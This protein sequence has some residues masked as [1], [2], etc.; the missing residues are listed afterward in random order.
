[1]SWVIKSSFSREHGG[2]RLVHRTDAA[3]SSRHKTGLWI[4]LAIAL[5][6]VTAATQIGTNRTPDFLQDYAAGWAWLHG[7]PMDTPTLVLAERFW[8]VHGFTSVQWLRQPH[9]PFATLLAI[10]FAF[11]SFES[12]R[13][14]WAGICV[15]AL[16]G[17]WYVGRVK[18]LNALSTAPIWCV[19]IVLG[20]HEP[21]LAL[22]IAA[23]IRWATI[24]PMWAGLS[25]GLAIALKCYPALLVVALGVLGMYRTALWATGIAVG[26]TLLAECCLG[27]GT[28]F[29]WL[30]IM[31]ENTARYV[32][33][34]SNGSLVRMVRVYLPLP[35]VFVAAACSVLLLTPL[36]LRRHT[37]DRQI[38]LQ[39]MISAM[40]LAS[41][42]SWRHYTGLAGF[43]PLG[44]T[45]HLLLVV[46]GLATL[47]VGMEFLPSAPETIIQI[48]LVAALCWQWWTCYFVQTSEVPAAEKSGGDGLPYYEPSSSTVL[49][50]PSAKSNSLR[51]GTI[52]A[53]VAKPYAVTIT[54]KTVSS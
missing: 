38:A 20:T 14:I 27:W 17:A 4:L 39:G 9:P 47:L 3:G 16:L 10:P 50:R 43:G 35:A 45:Q 42:L 51:A 6:S 18:P 21:L 13:W 49:D 44:R 19:A 25:L 2:D 34:S 28:L 36:Y 7:L 12:A 8:P 53:A 23:C 24:R 46:A 26:A 30:E 1:M 33:G 11:L 5:V 37:L 15:T 48:P 32:D 22:C 40:L 31:R 52:I 29:S 41:P 54:E